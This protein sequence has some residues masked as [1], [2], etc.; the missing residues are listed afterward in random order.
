M[1]IKGTETEKNLL[2][3]FAGESQAK[4]RYTYAAKVANKAGLYQIADLFMETAENEEQHAKTFF[5]YLEGGMVEITAAYPAGVIGDT[6]ENL[7]A[8]AE[9]EYEEWSELYPHFADVAEREGFKDVAISFRMIAKAEVAHEKRFRALLAR[10]EAEGVFK[11]EEPVEWKCRKC[12]YVHE[13]K[14]PPGKCP[15]CSHPTE[16]FEVKA[17]NY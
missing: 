14:N 6:A 8:A 16:Y 2:K 15:A 9:G 12:G 7:L 4:N 5:R 17:N 11:R 1:S 3:A 13:G 10:L